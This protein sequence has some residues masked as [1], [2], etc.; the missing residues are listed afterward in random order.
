MPELQAT[1]ET[2]QSLDPSANSAANPSAA[3]LDAESR[4]LRY[5]ADTKFTPLKECVTLIMQILPL[6]GAVL[7]LIFLL[8]FLGLEVTRETTLIEPLAVPQ[9]R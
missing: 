3:S 5:L 8:M 6:V 7:I 9:K 1:V 4:G 2:L